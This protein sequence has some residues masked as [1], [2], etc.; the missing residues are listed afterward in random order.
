M[1]MEDKSRRRMEEQ[2][3]REKIQ[4]ISGVFRRIQADN[5]GKRRERRSKEQAEYDALTVVEACA[6][7]ALTWFVDLNRCA[8]ALETLVGTNVHGG[9]NAT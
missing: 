2:Q 6:G 9:G 4:A 5:F 7:L 3:I 8:N 1:K